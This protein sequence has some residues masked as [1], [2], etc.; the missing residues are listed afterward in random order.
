M[1]ITGGNFGI[2]GGAYISR[3]KKLVIEGSQK[4]IYSQEDVG[5]VL[6]STSKER[7]FGAG[8]FIIGIIIFTV[9]LGLLF[10][11][12]GVLIAIVLS[13]LGSFYTEKKNTVEVQFNDGKS[14]TLDCTPRAV[15]KLVAFAPS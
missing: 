4:K 3:D 9:V 11:L 13:I 14:V 12:V 8:S 5:S 10:N 2:K 1:K 6:A 7:K 15:S